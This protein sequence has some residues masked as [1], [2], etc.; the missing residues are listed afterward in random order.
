MRAPTGPLLALA[1][2][3][4]TPARRPAHAPPGLPVLIPLPCAP[5]PREAGAHGGDRPRPGQRP[6][7]ALV[8]RVGSAPA[9]SCGHGCF[10]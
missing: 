4:G 10:G 9:G 3:P 5:P 1:P 7:R 6:S 2:P 8:C